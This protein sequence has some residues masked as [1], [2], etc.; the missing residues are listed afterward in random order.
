MTKPKDADAFAVV[1]PRIRH[2]KRQIE[3]LASLVD[4]EQDGQPVVVDGFR[5]RQLAQWQNYKTDSALNA[6]TPISGLCDSQCVFCF[7]RG[8]PF[9]KEQSLISIS[10][11]TT[12]LKH[13]SLATGD[14]LFPSSRPHM[15]PFVHPNALTLLE[16]A[17]AKD[18]DAVFWLTTN[19]S[20]LDESTIKHLASMKPLMLKLSLNAVDPAIR[21]DLMGTKADT[22]N[23]IAAPQLLN[24]HRIPFIGSIVAWP[25]V[26]LT[27]IEETVRYLESFDAYA[28]RVRLPLTH[29][30]VTQQLPVDFDDHW[31]TVREF[32]QKL[33]AICRVPLIVEPPIYS[34]DP[35]LPRVDGVILN[36][37]AYRA[38][39]RVNDIIESINGERVFTRTEAAGLLYMHHKSG[40][41]IRLTI[42]REGTSK[43]VWLC[44]S[45]DFEETYPY[46]PCHVYKGESYGIFHVDD[47]RL[48]YVRD[49]LDRIEEYNAQSVLLFTSPLVA[50]VLQTLIDRIPEFS[51]RFETVTLYIDSVSHNSFEGNFDLV[52][53]RLVDDYLTTIQMRLD[54]GLRI[55]LILLPNAFGTPWG[56]DLSGASCSEIEILT[57]V[58]VEVI[59]WHILYGRDV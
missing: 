39:V 43:D 52:D 56:V 48:A 11:A 23:A 27:S 13:F 47:F 16:M 15:E 35:I 2:L 14:C 55:D 10:E 3:R 12:R 22:A 4:L 31:K 21:R 20:R 42:S 46:D 37:P 36:S 29:R 32:C 58:P 6:I 45:E 17:R 53:S 54:L 8:T 24:K 44:D 5:L 26:P 51:K 9:P 33:R 34:I 57:G 59:D 25:T 40:E 50:P 38:E 30:W 18:P 41:R 7:E 28:I 1:E 49:I 19:G